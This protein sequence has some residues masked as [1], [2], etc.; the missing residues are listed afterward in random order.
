M[1]DGFSAN[2]TSTLP[3]LYQRPLSLAD[4]AQIRKTVIIFSAALLM[5]TAS[6]IAYIVTRKIRS[7]KATKKI[8][9]RGKKDE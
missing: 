4:D 1:F 9:I 5:V 8:D 3:K 7:K 6:L 2:I